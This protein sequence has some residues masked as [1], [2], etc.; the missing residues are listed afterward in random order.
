MT[1][2]EPRAPHGSRSAIRSSLRFDPHRT[3][4]IDE[5]LTKEGYILPGLGDTGDRLFN[6]T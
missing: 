5:K 4:A 2:G 3:G 1:S 6:T